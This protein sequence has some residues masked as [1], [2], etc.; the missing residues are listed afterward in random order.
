MRSIIR[1]LFSIVFFLLG[2]NTV[3]AQTQ[4]NIIVIVTDDAGYADWGFNQSDVIQTPQIDNLL[5]QGVQFSES[6]VTAS[7]CAP[8]RAGI[9]TGR[10]QNRYG[11]DFNIVNYFSAPD[12]QADDDGLDVN[13]LTIADRL[14]PLGYSTSAIGKWHLGD[15]DKF[16][17]LNRGFDYFYGLLDGSRPYFHTDGLS[18][19]KKLM[20]NW[21]YDDLVS[22]YMTDV[23][24]DDAIAW[25][26]SQ[27]DANKP[28]FTYL[29]YTA[30]HG[31][32]EA[33]QE[34]IDVFADCVCTE[35]KKTLAAMTYSLDYNIG[36]LVDSLKAKG[37]FDNTLIMFINDNGGPDKSG[38]HSNAPF[39]GYKSSAY[40]GGLRVP[41]AFVW[42]E[43]ITPNTVYDKQVISLDILP[44]V[45]LAAGGEIPADKVI[46]GVDLVPFLTNPDNTPHEYLFWR[47][48]WGYGV[49]KR[50]DKKMIVLYNKA[51]D[52]DNDTLLYDLS[53]DIGETTNIMSDNRTIINDF[54]Q[55]FNDW[56][57][58]MVLPY[59]I[60]DYTSINLCG[61]GV[62]QAEDCPYL[63][64]IYYPEKVVS[65]YEAENGVLT[66]TAEIATGCSY[67]SEG[68]FVKL[69][70]DTGNSLTFNVIEIETAGDYK[71]NIDYHMVG[72]SA[73]EIK[74]NDKSIGEYSF[75]SANWCYEGPASRMSLYVEL[76]TGLNSISFTVVDK[77]APFIDKISLNVAK[78][79]VNLELSQAVVEAGGDIEIIA[80]LDK[81]TLTEQMVGFQVSGIPNDLYTL[82]SNMITIEKNN[83]FGAV[84]LT[85]N[86][87][88]QNEE[89]EVGVIS[90]TGAS[91][92]LRL[93]TVLSEEV[94]IL[95]FV[96]SVNSQD[97]ISMLNSYPNPVN[98]RFTIDTDTE[99]I[100]KLKIRNLNG[101][102]VNFKYIGDNV[103][104]ISNLPG[105]IYIVELTTEDKKERIIKIVKE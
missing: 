40:E 74:V 43:H 102:T 12:M 1:R 70:N 65:V 90:L 28:F 63:M 94:T 30:V 71:L 88:N 14:K 97:N 84:T 93:G 55:R 11:F 77:P 25:M 19:G 96:T 20:R 85:P 2:I 60:G 44:T 103:V 82:S 95:K 69:Q 68:A 16:H 34:D 41:M 92:G 59:W 3:F 104:D 76:N 73:V 83:S 91:D 7:V 26:Q 10:Y 67:A 32:Y 54:S 13:E 56:E 5:S 39:R 18:S 105:G 29:S 15:D 24:T 8:S 79:K 75:P 64:D 23:L 72:S 31:P 35:E 61:K 99:K 51:G 89:D 52:F 4:P 66:G 46:D 9:L 58:D 37:V 57:K 22:G 33:E 48:I 42:P 49:V 62:S 86:I 21:D 101:H 50:A 98:D 6:Y 100:I 17:P 78:P 81:E 38:R 27:V 87:D 53:N 47:R 80:Q 45:L 36:K